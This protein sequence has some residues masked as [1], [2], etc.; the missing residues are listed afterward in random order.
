MR[1]IEK[2]SDIGT[3]IDSGSTAVSPDAMVYAKQYN[4]LHLH[5][6]ELRCREFGTSCRQV[7]VW[8]EYA[9]PAENP[10]FSRRQSMIVSDMIRE[11]RR[12]PS[13][14]SVRYQM[15]LT[16]AKRNLLR[17]MEAGLVNEAGKDGHRRL[18]IFNSD[19]SLNRVPG[20]R[21]R[22]T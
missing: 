5:C 22:C 11:G 20:S 12:H 14:A 15:S 10:G 19:E 17:I 3:I 4:N 13:E 8:A 9:E 16:T 18:H 6:D 1:I 21:N 2:S 7:G